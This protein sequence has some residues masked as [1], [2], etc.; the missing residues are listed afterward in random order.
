MVEY[1][2]SNL[3]V[4]GSSPA[5]LAKGCLP[6]DQTAQP[7]RSRRQ[8]SVRGYW[9]KQAKIKDFTVGSLL[10]YPLRGDWV[11]S[12]RSTCLLTNLASLKSGVILEPIAQW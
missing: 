12:S 11:I 8:P 2:I 10:Q 1:Q 5:S 9:S 3:S 7:P 4:V 6:G